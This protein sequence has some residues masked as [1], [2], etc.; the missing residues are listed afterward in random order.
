[1]LS[2]EKIQQIEAFISQNKPDE[3]LPCLSSYII[4]NALTAYHETLKSP[5][6]TYEI[7]G[8]TG[9]TTYAMYK[10]SDNKIFLIS[11]MI[12]KLV[13]YIE[14]ENTDILSS[15]HPFTH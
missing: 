9:F 13:S 2:L 8:S 14:I 12:Q 4:E 7:F 3:Y 10:S 11:V 5:E 1:M 15:Q 6:N